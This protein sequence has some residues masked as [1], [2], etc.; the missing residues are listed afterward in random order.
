MRPRRAKAYCPERTRNAPDA[1][2]GKSLMESDMSVGIA[3]PA[4][5]ILFRALRFANREF[6]YTITHGGLRRMI[7]IDG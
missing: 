1:V 7:S 3:D 5:R 6:V 2:V 4:D